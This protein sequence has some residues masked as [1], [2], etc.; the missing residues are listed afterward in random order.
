M[1]HSTPDPQ[2]RKFAIFLFFASKTHMKTKFSSQ[3]ISHMDNSPSARDAYPADWDL[4]QPE[5]EWSSE[6]TRD[7][8][9]DRDLLYTGDKTHKHDC[10]HARTTHSVHSRYHTHWHI[11]MFTLTDTGITHTHTC[12]LQKPWLDGISAALASLLLTFNL[13]LFILLSRRLCSRLCLS[14]FSH[15]FQFAVV[16]A[17]LSVYSIFHTQFFCQSY[18]FIF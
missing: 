4:Y 15:L 16:F 7:S 6:I 9:G 13:H 11:I 1:V 2:H 5:Q 3:L 12:T 10:I 14:S 18:Y 8:T 17:F